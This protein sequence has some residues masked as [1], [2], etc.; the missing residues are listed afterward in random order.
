M[1]SR[2]RGELTA[3]LSA[4]DFSGISRIVDVGGGQGELISAILKANPAMQGVLFDQPTAI[5]GARRRVESEG[6][7]DRCELV[8]GSFF[9]SVPAGGDGYILQGVIHNWNDSDATVILRKCRQA[10]GDNGRLLIVDH[11]LSTGNDP[12]PG[13]FADIIMMVLLGALERTENQYRGLLDAAGFRLTK[14][15]FTQG[16][17]IIE[18]EP[19]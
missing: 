1:T 13:K 9:E 15:I 19:A 7:S 17:S 4:Y 10:I 8:G 11:V 18:G 16:P 3:V 5:E 14:V 2:S 6:V 12:S